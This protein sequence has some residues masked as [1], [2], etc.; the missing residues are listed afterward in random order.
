M[1]IILP[2]IDYVFDCGQEKCTCIIVENQK[3]LYKILED[4]SVQMAGESGKTVVSEENITLGIGKYCELI[5]QFA[6]FD[7]NRKNLLTKVGTRMHQLAVADEHY[8]KIQ[9]ILAGW[10]RYLMELSMEMVGNFE[11]PKISADSLIKAAGVQVENSY[12]SL[13]EELLDY[14][15]LVQEYDMKKLFVLVNLRS[16][17][18]DEEM[19]LFL[20]GILNRR[21]EV[22]LLESTER[23]MLE[24]EERY[25]VDRDLCVIH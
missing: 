8:L 15:E 21:I 6:P 2:E 18:S 24:Y 16:Y 14:F 17:L 19:N 5:S 3:L 23:K 1:K 13:G 12:D 7:I 22:L 20:E 11:F 25:I 10:E 4:L 9:E